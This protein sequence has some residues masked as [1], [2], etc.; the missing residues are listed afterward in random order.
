[1]KKILLSLLAFFSI[2]AMGMV[3]ETAVF[4]FKEPLN[5]NMSPSLSAVD[6]NT[7]AEGDGVLLQITDR[8]ISSGAVTISFAKQSGTAGAGIAHFG[9]LFSLNLGRL[10]EITFSVSGG[11]V[12]SSI[13]F[14]QDS[15]IT[16]PSGQKGSWNY[17]T[18]IWSAAGNNDINTV[19]LKKG[20]ATS[21]MY[22]ITVKY[23]RPSNPLNFNSSIPAKNETVIGSFKTMTLYFNTTVSKV[24]SVS[25]IKLTGTDVDNTTINQSM[26]AAISGNSVI[27]A[28]STAIVKDASL[29]VTIPSGTFETSEGAVNMSDIIIPFSLLAKRDIFN[30]LDI[31][32]A[33]GTVQELPQ[34]IQLTF[35]NFV[36]IAPNSKVKF[37]KQGSTEDFPAV[38]EVNSTNKKIAYIKHENGRLTDAAT[39]VVEIPAKVF[40]N[41]YIDDPVDD[42]W[43]EAMTLTYV[44]DGTATPDDPNPPVQDSETMKLAKSLL[45]DENKT[46]VGY[47]SANSSGWQN[48]YNLV[49]TSE[50]PSDEV[51]QEKIDA[52]YTE[53]NVNL[54]QVG[55]WYYIA[56]VNSSN[57][58]IFLCFNEDKTKVRLEKG[59]ASAAA[60][61][62]VAQVDATNK[63]IIFKTKGGLFLHLPHLLSNYTPD[64]MTLTNGNNSN[65]ESIKL[66]DTKEI[67]LKKCLTDELG[68]SNLKANSFEPTYNL[69]KKDNK[70]I[71]RI[72]ASGNTNLEA[73]EIEFAGEYN[74]IKIKGEKKKDKEPVNKEE[75][76]FNTR[77]DGKF[78]F[79]V[80]LKAEDYL[81]SNEEAEIK[82]KR[83][84]FMVEFKLAQKAKSKGHHISTEDEI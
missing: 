45:K 14:D 62:Q 34:S 25:A 57:E 3:E 42:R 54:P 66:K 38:L 74:I 26:T 76:I 46:L 60:A 39:W 58:R 30:P 15:D 27:L 19:T 24:N 1:M 43:N 53:T 79:E 80:P 8:T 71:L 55:Q 35:N 41:Q 23:L 4:N 51:L 37:K 47:P 75:N 56:G 18:N 16:L 9:N 20:D 36:A 32:P 82:D 61:F 78:S 10:C 6:K 81:L 33:S 22:T 7:I 64:G 83:G 44:V 49:N 72:E 28:A 67:V 5:L 11:C 40:H 52:Y 13:Q 68:F 29:T 73:P 31:N 21:K 17:M 65:P 63:T 69:Y 2:H 48:L 77:E 50:T 12:L 84:V 59:S 70:I